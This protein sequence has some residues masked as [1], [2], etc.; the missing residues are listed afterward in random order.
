[1]HSPHTKLTTRTITPTTVFDVT[2]LH[3]MSAVATPVSA[4]ADDHSNE[5]SSPDHSEEHHEAHN[6]TV[7]EVPDEEDTIKRHDTPLSNSVLEDVDSGPESAPAGKRYEKP[8]DR[9]IIEKPMKENKPKA[10]EISSKEAFPE[11]GGGKAQIPAVAPSWGGAKTDALKSGFDSNSTTASGAAT[12]TSS[13]SAPFGGPGTFNMPGQYR[14]QISFMPDDLIPR[15]EMRRPLP[16]ILKD[17]NRKFKVN[18]TYTT[19]ERNMLFFTAT[20]PTKKAVTE[21]L[22]ELADKITVT[23]SAHLL[24]LR[25]VR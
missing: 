22:V 18:L 21:A 12:P 25:G 5:A 14:E 10:V 4:E 24:F 1:M 3:I 17:I 23:V 15:T 19:G 6:P 11:L 7:E 2:S 20:G 13:K 8:T 16:D 9:K